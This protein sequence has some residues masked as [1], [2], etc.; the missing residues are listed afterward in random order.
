MGVFLTGVA[1]RKWA[2]DNNGRKR[3]FS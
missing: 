3:S 2:I 1:N